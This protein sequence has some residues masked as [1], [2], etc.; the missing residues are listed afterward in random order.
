MTTIMIT[1]AGRGI[2]LEL[3]R[4]A[5]AKGL[6][7]IALARSVSGAVPGRVFEG[8]D[9]TDAASL[10][11]VAAALEGVPVDVLVNNAG[12]IG[13]KRQAT[14][15]MDFDGFLQALNVNTVAPLRVVDT[16]LPN[17]RA[18]RDANGAARIV[19]IS[20]WMGSL[21]HTK[22]DRIAYRAS[23]AAVNKVMQGLAA[24]LAGESIFVRSMHPG[25]VRTDMGGSGA[26]IDVSESA[27][28]ILAR[29]LELDAATT[30]SYTNYD[31]KPLAW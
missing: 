3:A 31:G 14:L 8:V 6:N 5:E 12:V 20:S 19:T 11:K 26:D 24:D 30:G 7:V 22:S 29:A 27:A 1:G 17:L 15:D 21:S 10:D 4:Q 13:P 23:K 9:V 28:G 2:G 16:F 18:A 25:W